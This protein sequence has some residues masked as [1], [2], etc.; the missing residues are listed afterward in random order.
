MIRRLSGSSP[1]R[2]AGV[3]VPPRP[4]EVDP[5]AP[6]VNWDGVIEER[7]GDG[8]AEQETN[9]E[10]WSG[11]MPTTSQE[12]AAGCAMASHSAA[13]SRSRSSTTASDTEVYRARA[14]R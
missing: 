1:A 5:S 14:Q 12:L 13:G 9:A 11:L 7:L 4:V 10:A 2:V 8:E 3:P 6:V